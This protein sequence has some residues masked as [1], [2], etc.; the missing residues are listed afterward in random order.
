MPIFE[1]LKRR[2]VF[3]VGVAYLIGSWLVLQVMDVV[4]P[5]LELQNWISRGLLLFLAVGFVVAVFLA[6]AYELTPE[7]VKREE[8]V[9]RSTSITP[10]TGRK[11]DFVIIGILSIAVIFFAMEKLQWINTGSDIKELEKSIAV[12]PFDNRSADASDAYFV[13][14]IH[15]DILTQLHKISGIDKVISRTSVERYRDTELSIPEIASQL[16]VATIL[17]GSVQRAGDRVR[18]T[19]QLIGAAN[20]EHLW[21]DN[22]DRELTTA[23][24]FEIQSEISV[25]IAESLQATLTDSEAG[26]LSIIPTDSLEAYDAYLLGKHTMKSREASDLLRALSYFEEAISIDPQFA[27]AYVG[28]ADSLILHFLYE[29]Q[30]GSRDTTKEWRSEQMSEAESA[31]L[32]ALE[33]NDQ[34]GEAY[35]S[36]AYAAVFRLG[37]AESDEELIQQIDSNF[38]TAFSLSPNYADAYRWYSEF[39]RKDNEDN[40]ENSLAMAVRAV[41]LDPMFA[42]NQSALAQARDIN[43]MFESAVQSFDRAI[44][45]APSIDNLHYAKGQMLLARGKLDRVIV[46]GSA[47][48]EV[49]PNSSMNLLQTAA[50]YG[51]L[52]MTEEAQYLVSRVRESGPNARTRSLD[53]FEARMRADYELSF[54]LY[55]NLLEDLPMCFPCIY[56]IAHFLKGGGDPESLQRF[57][58]VYGGKLLDDDS[59]AVSAR[60]VQLVPLAAWALMETGQTDSARRLVELGPGHCTQESSC[61][62]EW[63]QR[64]NCR[65]R[66]ACTDGK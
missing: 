4:A 51:G 61:K 32:R 33:I 48:L 58:R 15:D 47:I 8:D 34:L 57:L 22:F 29:S 49:N 13:D 38:L 63:L 66:N 44:E 26:R 35:A 31:A 54:E 24:V 1:E 37:V 62:R 7:G 27:L 17:E 25:A 41:E 12:L 3:R 46:T 60:T 18:I 36:L 65:C 20:D 30:F 45:L 5:I 52:G 19:V 53:A 16:G 56:T 43:D 42:L 39:L 21:A 64:R 2:N 40:A 23:N 14:G 28:I 55:L 59:P 6:W 10:Q 9:D 11:L 50:A